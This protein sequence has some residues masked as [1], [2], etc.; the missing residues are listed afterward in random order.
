MMLWWSAGGVVTVMSAEMEVEKGS[1][2][3][4]G[5]H[6]LGWPCQA[7]RGGEH[8]QQDVCQG[9]NL[10]PPQLRSAG[11]MP[12]A[13]TSTAAQQQVAAQALSPPSSH[14]QVPVLGASPLDTMGAGGRPAMLLADLEAAGAALLGG[15]RL[16][17]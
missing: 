16:G 4:R 1:Q 14:G 6:H 10:P 3:N 8:P 12:S 5:E 11:S 7:G 9:W 2:R 15:V 13:P 17:C